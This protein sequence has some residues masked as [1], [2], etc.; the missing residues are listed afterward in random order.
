MLTKELIRTINFKS[1]IKNCSLMLLFISL[2]FVHF[3]LAAQVNKG[4]LARPK[5]WVL[6][7]NEK[8]FPKFSGSWEDS[9]ALKK[10]GDK[11]E[12]WLQSNPA[13][14]K[15]N[16]LKKKANVAIDHVFFTS[17]NVDERARFKMVSKQMS[18][19]LLPQKNHLMREFDRSK[20]KENNMSFVNDAE[21]V[22]FLHYDNVLQLKKVI[23]N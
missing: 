13:F 14:R 21:Q 19:A 20:T 16:L 22:Y 12:Q 15:E 3:N 18:Y 6:G 7:V 2:Q 23:R 9:I 10:Y 4:K 11:V 1:T 17:L 5:F 8:D